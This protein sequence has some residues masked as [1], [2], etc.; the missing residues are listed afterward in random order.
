MS[1]QQVE[2]CNESISLLTKEVEALASSLREKE[3]M[4]AQLERKLQSHQQ[5]ASTPEQLLELLNLAPQ[6]A[7]LEH[8]LQEA[9]HKKQKAELEREMAIKEMEVQKKFQIQLHAQLGVCKSFFF[10]NCSHAIA[11][12]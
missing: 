2:A 8:K 4:V 6:I 5:E 3:N 10:N 11:G 9:E 12:S 7:E 1:E